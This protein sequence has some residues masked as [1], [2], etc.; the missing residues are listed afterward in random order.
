[1]LLVFVILCSNFMF[2][3]AGNT[4]SVIDIGNELIP[5]VREPLRLAVQPV[6]ESN[7]SAITNVT[8]TAYTTSLIPDGSKID[9]YTGNPSSPFPTTLLGSS[10]VKGGKAVFKTYQKINSCYLGSAVWTNPS[11]SISKFPPTRIYSNI[12]TYNV[13]LSDK[14]LDLNVTVR[15]FV[16]KNVSYTARFTDPKDT[17]T[18]EAQIIDPAVISSKGTQMKVKFSTFQISSALDIKALDKAAINQISVQ[19]P[20]REDYAIIENWTAK[21][22]I[23]LPAGKYIVLAECSELTANYDLELFNVSQIIV[24]P[25][26]PVITKIPVSITP[27][28]VSTPPVL[29]TPPVKITPPVEVTLPVVSLPV[30]II[31]PDEIIQYETVQKF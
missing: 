23:N 19:K 14:L 2:V 22:N 30:D 26:T 28:A 29:V 16:E 12:V 4:N 25:S 10:Y 17:Q 3:S 6:Y 7:G 18:V 1:M 21:V 24:I 11:E 9:F 5:I 13:L 8:Y 15:N 31:L 27:I 20:Y